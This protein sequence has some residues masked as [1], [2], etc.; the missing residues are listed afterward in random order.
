MQCIDHK[1]LPADSG[2]FKLPQSQSS[3]D[4]S[5]Y[6]CHLCSTAVA[7]DS[8]ACHMATRFDGIIKRS[9]RT[10]IELADAKVA[11]VVLG[12]IE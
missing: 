6:L 2:Q 7:R 5:Q 10:E 1:V 11:K 8:H 3:V 4:S 12:R 9:E